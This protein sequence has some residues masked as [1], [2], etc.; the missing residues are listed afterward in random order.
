VHQQE[1]ISLLSLKYRFKS[2]YF[3]NG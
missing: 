3:K 1:T 2:K